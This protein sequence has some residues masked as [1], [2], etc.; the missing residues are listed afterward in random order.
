MKIELQVER[1]YL[2]KHLTKFV[3]LGKY[4]DLELN[5]FT[6]DH[7]GIVESFEYGIII[8]DVKNFIYFMP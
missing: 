4:L 3:Y 7:F 1:L 5:L 2:L 8:Y 6:D